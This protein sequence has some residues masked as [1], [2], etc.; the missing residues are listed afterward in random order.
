MTP[1]NDLDKC[2]CCTDPI[3]Y[4]EYT[5]SMNS[6]G[7]AMCQPCTRHY[8]SKLAQSEPLER[9]LYAALVKKGIRGA[10]LQYFDGVKTVD[11]AIL[12]ARLHIEIHGSHHV[13]ASQEL[14]DMWRSNYSLKRSDVLTLRIP[15]L[16]VLQDVESAATLINKVVALRQSAA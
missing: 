7:I 6:F 10:E 11:I 13:H 8:T 2:M 14:T 4:R 12:P 5:H 1:A 16:V 9:V 3:D 15:N